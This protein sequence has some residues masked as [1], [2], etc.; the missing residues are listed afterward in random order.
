MAKYADV[1]DLY[2]DNGKLLKSNVALE[3]ISPLVNPAIKSLVDNAKRTVAVNLGG[4]EAALKNGKIGKHQQILGRELNLDIAGNIDAIEAKIKQYVS[5]EEGDDTEIRRFNDGKLL[6]VKVPKARIE[7]AATY[8]ASLLSVAA[9]TTYALVEEFN[10]DMFDANTVKAAV[11]GSYPVSQALDG[12]ACSM[13]M[14]IPQNNESLGYALRNIPA[15][16]TVMMT[17]RNAMQGAALAATFEQA[18]QF[19]MANAV[20]P[21]ERAQLLIYA[22]Q[23]L[24]ANNIVYDLVKENGQTGT[25]G[26]VMQSLVERAVEDKV[27]TQTAGQAGGYFKPYETKDPMLWNAYASAG[28]LAATMVNAGAGRFAQAVSSTLLYFNDILEHETGLPGADYGRVMGAA[29]G[30]SFFSHSIYGGGGPGIF[31]GNHVV[32]RH[33]AGN[34]IPCIVAACALDAGTQMFSPEGTAK[35][36]GD[37]FGSIEEFAHPLQAIAKAV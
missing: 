34:G 20:G 1:I 17:H 35:I 37:T 25:V 29:V 32:T 14:S 19:E 6:L 9:A 13:I 12:G 3:K 11:F 24:N 31:N 30:F 15:N 16:Q 5:V 23:G 21:F 26:T 4:V 36:Y 8:D 28:T 27:I 2:D 22:Y 10:V 7:A 33:A 18:G